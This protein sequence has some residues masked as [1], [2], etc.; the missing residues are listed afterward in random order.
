MT[1][2]VHPSAVVEAGAELGSGVIVG[3]LC[4]VATGVEVGDGTELVAQATLLG[5]AR[6]GAN[7][8]IFPH[9]VL[10]APPQDKSHAGEPTRLEIGDENQI[11]E[12]VTVHRGTLKGGGVT[13]VGSR[14]MLMAGSHVAHDCR[15]G[16]DVVLTNL[17]TLGGH[18]TVGDNVV[19]GGL[20]AVAQYV[21]L[22][23]GCFLAG[24]AMVESD[25]PPF[26][27]A[28][29]DRARVRALNR[30]GLKRLGVPEASRRALG[31]AFRAIFRAREP[32][33]AA[34]LRAR[35]KHGAD[36]YVSELLEFL[37]DESRGQR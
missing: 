31:A 25:V 4:Y 29:G 30:V 3:P 22:G 34:I 19:C 8:R 2:T 23:R 21:W 13:R 17:V 32:R 16:N 28:A 7:N 20:A 12:H 35:E 6:I 27:I 33:A 1:A 15:V 26:V 36:P 18:V 11:R 5:P 9:A 14:C 10:G 37:A 24:G